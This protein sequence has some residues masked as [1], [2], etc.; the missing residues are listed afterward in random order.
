MKKALLLG[1]F[2]CLV[3]SIFGQTQPSHLELP[4]TFKRNEVGLNL[5]YLID[6]VFKEQ[7]EDPVESFGIL[8]RGKEAFFFIQKKLRCHENANRHWVSQFYFAGH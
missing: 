3:C 1:W 6:E 7:A 8:K 4:S 2:L 5:Y